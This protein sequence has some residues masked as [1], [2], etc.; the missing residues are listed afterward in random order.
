MVQQAQ[1]LTMADIFRFRSENMELNINT[2]VYYKDYYGIDDEVYKFCQRTYLF[3][4]DKEYSDTLQ[5]IGIVPIIAPQEIYNR[6]NYKEK[7]KF[8]CNKNVVSV[9]IKM[10]FDN[11]YNVNS[12]E[13]I[14]QTKEMI[15]RA[16]ERIKTKVK[17]DYDQFRDD[18][19]S[20]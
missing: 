11:Y 13:K 6:K 10:D 9:E 16:V 7:V 2:P 3:F 8:L 15:L 14:E 19:M 4:K 17:F 1:L 12:T 18:L 5:I 20:L